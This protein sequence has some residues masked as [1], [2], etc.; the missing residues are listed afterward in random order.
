MFCGNVFNVQL[1]D[2]DAGS[3]R[4]SETFR[5]GGQLDMTCAK[6]CNKM[7]NSFYIAKLKTC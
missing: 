1:E 7:L 5:A 3:V 6:L 4:S 2:L